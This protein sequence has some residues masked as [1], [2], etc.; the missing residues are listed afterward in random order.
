MWRHWKFLRKIAKISSNGFSQSKFSYYYRNK[1]HIDLSKLSKYWFE[2]VK[3]MKWM[4]CRGIS[5]SLL[6]KKGQGKQTDL[7]TWLLKMKQKQL[8][9]IGL[10]CL[11]EEF[12]RLYDKMKRC[13]V[14]KVLSKECFLLQ[15][16]TFLLLWIFLFSGEYK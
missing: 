1:L 16:H 8:S 3:Q 15:K 7:W 12:K 11:W 14:W 13:S 6:S 4:I 9:L 2:I 5:N 10:I